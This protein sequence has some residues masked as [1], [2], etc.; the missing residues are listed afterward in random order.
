MCSLQYDCYYD[1]IFDFKQ[2]L[3]VLCNFFHDLH[4]CVILDIAAFSALCRMMHS[5]FVVGEENAVTTQ[6]QKI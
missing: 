1:C 4:T 3:A 6:S 2:S 5:F